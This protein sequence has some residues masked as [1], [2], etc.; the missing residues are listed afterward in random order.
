M[1][2]D[3]EGKVFSGSIKPGEVRNPRGNPNM[4]IGKARKTGPVTQ[5]GKLKN[6][7]SMISH[8]KNS[9]LISLFRNC[10]KCPLRETTR[11]VMSRGEAVDIAIPAKCKNYTVGA[12]CVVPQIDFIKKLRFYY[13][14]GEKLGTKELQRVITYRTLEM[15]EIAGETEILEDRKPGYF[16]HKFFEL[17][18]KNTESMNKLEYGEKLTTQNLNV[19]MNIS[20]MIVGAYRE[21]KEETEKKEEKEDI[22]KEK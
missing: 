21:S 10:D 8:G 11:E 3:N 18:G 15:A 7:L 4:N 22:N 14:I 16:T 1:I 13:D 12:K 5:E 19:N 9:K 17:A 6:A 20:D 2:P